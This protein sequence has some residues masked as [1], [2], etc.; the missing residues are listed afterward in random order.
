MESVSQWRPVLTGQVSTFDSNKFWAI[1]VWKSWFTVLLTNH[2]L[3]SITWSW[4]SVLNDKFSVFTFRRLMTCSMHCQLRKICA[5]GVENISTP[6]YVQSWLQTTP[7]QYYGSIKVLQSRI[8]VWPEY[9]TRVKIQY[10]KS[11]LSLQDLTMH[12]QLFFRRSVRTYGSVVQVIHSGF[13]IESG[14]MGLHPLS[15]T[16]LLHSSLS[17]IALYNCLKLM[18]EF[19]VIHGWQ[20]LVDWGGQSFKSLHEHETS[21][22]C[23]LFES[24]QDLFIYVS[25]LVWGMIHIW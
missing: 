20:S 21:T 1:Y 19:L 3:A 10:F 4:R 16:L 5:Q 9:S 6:I 7:K 15:E 14:E 13:Q 25:V 11:S 2:Q 23:E 18:S 12:I 24:G 8:F 22:V 17:C